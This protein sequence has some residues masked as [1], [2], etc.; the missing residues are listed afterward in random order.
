[1]EEKIKRKELAKQMWQDC[2]AFLK[3]MAEKYQ[4][5]IIKDS[6]LLEYKKKEYV[7]TWKD[8]INRENGFRI[9]DYPTQMFNIRFEVMDDYLNK[10]L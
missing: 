6:A 5:I 2:E 8:E 4:D 3:E 10:V 1:M 9:L 7:S